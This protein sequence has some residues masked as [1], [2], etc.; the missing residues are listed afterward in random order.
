MFIKKKRN[1]NK[2]KICKFWNKQKYC[3]K[4]Q[5]KS[6]EFLEI[7]NKSIKTK[8]SVIKNFGFINWEFEKIKKE[9]KNL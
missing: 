1:T 5:A 9:K 7:Y 3:E 2:T 6:Q 4:F 8:K